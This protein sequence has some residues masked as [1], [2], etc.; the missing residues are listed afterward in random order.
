MIDVNDLRKGVAFEQDGN[1]FRVTDYSHNKA[2]RG[3]A[4]IRIKARNLKTGANVDM[5]FISGD[6]VPEAGLDHHT[7]Q[8]LYTDGDFYHFMDQETYEQPALR[9]EMLEGIEQYLIEGMELKLTLWAGEPLDL[10]IPL[11]VE[12]KIVNMEDAIRGDT[13]TGVSARAITET[14]LQVSVPAFVKKGD[15]IRIDTRTGAY[16][17]RV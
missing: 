7:V 4:S 1:L 9:K 14:G 15:T 16:V 10:E 17:T 5:T 6:R 13:A 3:K 11:A 2:G 8:Y 12:H